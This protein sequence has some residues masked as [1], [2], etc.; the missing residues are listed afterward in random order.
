MASCGRGAAGPGGEQTRAGPT[1][2]QAETRG[3]AVE[4]YSGDPTGPH[5]S[6]RAVQRGERSNAVNEMVPQGR[7]LELS[8][9]A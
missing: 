1:F 5:S 6:T 8:C 2:A 9:K 3:Q 4:V 7:A